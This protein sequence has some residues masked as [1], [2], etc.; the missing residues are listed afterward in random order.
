MHSK[1]ELTVFLHEADKKL[2]NAYDKYETVSSSIREARQALL[3]DLKSGVISRQSYSVVSKELMR[4]DK[5]LNETYRL[6]ILEQQ[7]H[8]KRI[9]QHVMN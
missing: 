1:D 3:D 6:P 9:L 2:S 4:Q 5:E 8:R 7:Q